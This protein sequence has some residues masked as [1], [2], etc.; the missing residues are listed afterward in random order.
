MDDATREHAGACYRALAINSRPFDTA[1]MD[2]A[3]RQYVGHL[4][5]RSLQDAQ[6]QL[7]EQHAD[8]TYDGFLYSSMNASVVVAISP[9]RA[10]TR[11][12]A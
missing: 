7:V 2:W 10:Q 3:A 4:V 1:G 8:S 6:D 5:L 9:P 12:T 11:R